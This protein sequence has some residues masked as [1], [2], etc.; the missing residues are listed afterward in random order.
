MNGSGKGS[1]GGGG[2]KPSRIS[3][4][5]EELEKTRRGIRRSR[6]EKKEEVDS[7]EEE[8]G[9]KRSGDKRPPPVSTS[10]S[11]GSARKPKTPSFKEV[12]GGFREYIE[13]MIPDEILGTQTEEM[14]DKVKR[15]RRISEKDRIKERRK[16]EVELKRVY[17]EYKSE[18]VKKRKIGMR[19]AQ[20]PE[21]KRIYPGPEP[22]GEQGIRLFVE[23]ALNELFGEIVREEAIE[24]IKEAA[25]A[26]ILAERERV[27][28][29]LAINPRYNP[30][31]A[32]SGAMYLPAFYTGNGN[33]SV[34][35][36]VGFIRNY[37]LPDALARAV[38]I[39]RELRR[40]DDIVPVLQRLDEEVTQRQ[41][42]NT[43]VSDVME[44]MLTQIDNTQVSDVMETML[45]QL[46]TED[47]LQIAA[48]DVIDNAQEIDKTD[49]ASL[50]SYDDLFGPEDH[51]MDDQEE[52]EGDNPPP[53]GGPDDGGD[54]E[55]PEDDDEP[56][57]DEDQDAILRA[58]F[59]AMRRNVIRTRVFSDI[60]RVWREA[61]DN[62]TD[63]EV[64]EEG[65]ALR[66]RSVADFMNEFMRFENFNHD[67][68]DLLTEFDNMQRSHMVLPPHLVNDF[69]YRF[70]NILET[71][72]FDSDTR[73]MLRDRIV[74][75]WN[76]AV[77]EHPTFFKNYVESDADFITRIDKARN[78]LEKISLTDPSQATP[79]LRKEYEAIFKSIRD[80][81]VR[82]NE[83]KARLFNIDSVEEGVRTL[84]EKDGVTYKNNP[85]YILHE[86]KYFKNASR[87]KAIANRLENELLK[88]EPN[89]LTID[90]LKKEFETLKNHPVTQDFPAFKAQYGIMIA[91]AR[92]KFEKE[93]KAAIN[94]VITDLADKLFYKY[95]EG[96]DY[97]IIQ[98]FKEIF[99]EYYDLR[100]EAGDVR[101]F[102]KAVKN[103]DRLW[104]QEIE[105]RAEMLKRKIDMGSKPTRD[106]QEIVTD[107]KRRAGI[108]K[109]VVDKYKKQSEKEGYMY[110]P[111]NHEHKVYNNLVHN[112][113]V[114][115]AEFSAKEVYKVM[116]K[117]F[118][119]DWT[120]AVHKLEAEVLELRTAV[121]DDISCFGPF[122]NSTINKI[123]DR[124]RQK[125]QEVGANDRMRFDAAIQSEKQMVQK[126]ITK[127]AYH[128]T[129][130]KIM[131][132]A[133]SS[134][135]QKFVL[136]P[137]S[138]NLADRNNLVQHT[139]AGMYLSDTRRLLDIVRQSME[140]RKKMMSQV[141]RQLNME[142]NANSIKF[143][144]VATNLFPPSEVEFKLRYLMTLDPDARKKYMN[145][146]FIQAIKMVD[147]N[148]EFSDI[149]NENL[150]EKIN[151]IAQQS[152]S[153]LQTVVGPTPVAWGDFENMAN[154]LT[155]SKYAI[156]SQVRD[157]PVEDDQDQIDRDK[158]GP[159]D[160]FQYDQDAGASRNPNGFAENITF[161]PTTQGQITRD[162]IDDNKRQNYMQMVG[163]MA[164]TSLEP[165][166][167]E[168]YVPMHTSSAKF[169]FDGGNYK[170]LKGQYQSM[171]PL[172][173]KKPVDDPNGFI[174]ETLAYYG[175][176]LGIKKRKS[177]QKDHP[178]YL[179]KEA[180]ELQELVGA[181]TNYTTVTGGNY[182]HDASNQQQPQ[183]PQVVEQQPQDANK[184]NNTNINPTS[185]GEEKS[186]P[187]TSGLRS[188]FNNTSDA[189]PNFDMDWGPNW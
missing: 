11:G 45:T 66:Q 79:E 106:P 64:L 24:H 186:D 9:V 95:T 157:K 48:A 37:L 168:P 177:A 84:I 119:Q 150:I 163:S 160:E 8:W 73:S 104:F 63:E 58:A 69:L 75:I 71:Q 52:K 187:L 15:N 173:P 39:R 171:R 169:Y 184:D 22:M 164:I 137:S 18:N 132:A 91:D 136:D 2:K 96:Q 56:E 118:P 76:D 65:D 153:F 125:I 129:G 149:T 16:R 124:F 80:D 140:L 127:E 167:D 5:L 23:D 166:E 32:L 180:I 178:A 161:N 107:I 113:R 27:A 122:L 78:R 38:Q 130:A 110:E 94:S 162:K 44:T 155:R 70:S 85:I 179:Q 133:K 83:A 77:K 46:E 181:Y 131:N 55:D 34:D 53:Q 143:D 170:N 115:T 21:H 51:I 108:L 105:E 50:E 147:D 92:Q 183:A 14:L 97:N 20:D 42:D 185:T 135:L 154:E 90:K 151:S 13:A 159:S 26:Q 7:D 59:E 152:K 144:V 81:E 100:A 68:N 102:N 31:R 33:R 82:Y 1:G 10:A 62:Y 19:I 99:N 49:G 25:T 116:Y 3:K 41:I 111:A 148:F 6:E 40:V 158:P 36:I 74:R 175:P 30:Y 61:R 134:T 35:S 172:I 156:L 146:R 17:N 28:M 57:R 145:G 142:G 101:K 139:P 103:E 47:A 72:E 182:V 174:E 189:D 138:F 128:R 87:M 117:D 98:N 88:D 43:Q 86:K 67:L 12:R 188:V 120:D 109:Q 4:A 123:F 141:F 176:V 29:L 114:A 54:P 165:S 60:T 121:K 112:E 126:I 89:V 93:Q